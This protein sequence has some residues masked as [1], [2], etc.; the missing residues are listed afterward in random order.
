[1]AR[2]FTLE[3]GRRLCSCFTGD[4]RDVDFYGNIK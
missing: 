4:L 1:M 2:L 3:M